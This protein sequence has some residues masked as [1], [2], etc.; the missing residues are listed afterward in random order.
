MAMALPDADRAGALSLTGRQRESWKRARSLD[1][2]APR[3]TTSASA[4]RRGSPMESLNQVQRSK[5]SV[6]PRFR[7]R[8]ENA[9][10]PLTRIARS[11]APPSRMVFTSMVISR[12]SHSA[13]EA[14]ASGLP[15]P[16]R[17]ISTEK[18]NAMN[19]KGRGLA[20]G[21][22]ALLGDGQPLAGLGEHDGEEPQRLGG[23]DRDLDDQAPVHAIAVAGIDREAIA[24]VAALAGE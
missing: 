13:N 10:G 2:S 12:P 1:P 7:V 9:T 4:R 22:S 6:M 19:G 21:T 17:W 24:V 5:L 18:L 14:S 16:S 8:F 20:S 3:I 11:G 23:R 15:L